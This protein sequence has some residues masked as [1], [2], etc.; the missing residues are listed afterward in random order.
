MCFNGR[1]FVCK[2]G[3][4]WS[5]QWEIQYPVRVTSLC[6]SLY[7][8]RRTEIISLRLS[9]LRRERCF[10]WISASKSTLFI[11]GVRETEYLYVIDKNKSGDAE[12]RAGCVRNGHD[13]LTRLKKR[14]QRQ[15]CQRSRQIF[16]RLFA[17]SSLGPI[18]RKSREKQKSKKSTNYFHLHC[19]RIFL[20]VENGKLYVHKILYMCAPVYTCGITLIL[21]HATLLPMIYSFRFYVFSHST[22]FLRPPRKIWVEI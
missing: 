6:V 21:F 12:Y 9:Q 3:W 16:G 7:N 22:F 1:L 18:W 10:A 8:A 14:W 19:S 13:G 20:T 2:T 4:S 17:G 5:I 11:A 15:K